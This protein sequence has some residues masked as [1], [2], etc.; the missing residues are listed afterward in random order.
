MT[1]FHK[2]Y[3]FLNRLF[4]KKCQRLGEDYGFGVVVHRLVS[5]SAARRLSEAQ[6]R[7]RL[8]TINFQRSE[9]LGRIEIARKQKKARQHLYD[10]Q[11]LLTNEALDIESQ[12]ASVG[13]N[14]I[15]QGI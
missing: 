7:R 10:A 14:K 11:A 3:S 1:L 6:L 2:L 8:L 15:Y 13:R 4:G 5:G 9:L 12:L